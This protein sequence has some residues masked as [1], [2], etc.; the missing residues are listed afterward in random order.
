[1]TQ[2]M[3]FVILVAVA[4]P[5][6]P[7]SR[8]DTAALIRLALRSKLIPPELTSDVRAGE[9]SVTSWVRGPC[10]GRAFDVE[11]CVSAATM[12]SE[13][14]ALDLERRADVLDAEVEELSERRPE[15]TT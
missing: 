11:S 12:T 13:L 9:T 8:R 15:P 1:M 3:T 5:K 6:P 14:R 10:C 2:R 7:H 4:S